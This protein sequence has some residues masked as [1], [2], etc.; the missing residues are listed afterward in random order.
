MLIIDQK[1]VK[2]QKSRSEIKQTG[3]SQNQG[4]QKI[5]R[6]RQIAKYGLKKVSN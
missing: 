6:E 5:L 1:W 3:E 2:T 4:D